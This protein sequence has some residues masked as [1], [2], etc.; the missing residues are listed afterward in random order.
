[1]FGLWEREKKLVAW[2]IST[3][4]IATTQSIKF[5]EFSKSLLRMNKS[6]RWLE[7]KVIPWV[8]KGEKQQPYFYF[9]LP[10]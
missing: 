10:K 2:I 9:A 3:T 7:V 4:F 5:H 1:M 8:I 6:L